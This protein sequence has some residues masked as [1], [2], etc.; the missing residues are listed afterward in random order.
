MT[1]LATW[2]PFPNS[3]SVPAFTVVVPVKVL[4][5]TAPKLKAPPP[6]SVT[7][8]APLMSPVTDP[9]IGHERLADINRQRQPPSVVRLAVKLDLTR[10]PVKIGQLKPRDLDRAQ[11]QPCEQHQHRDK[12]RLAAGG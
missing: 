4:G 10:P 9:Q 6:I 1:R 7:P 2:L 5:T 3:S 12:Q 11:P 8:P